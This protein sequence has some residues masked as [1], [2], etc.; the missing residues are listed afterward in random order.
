MASKIQ[1]AN[2]IYQ[3]QEMQ[4]IYKTGNSEIYKIF[5]MLP[6]TRLYK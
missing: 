6:P 4:T 2:E 5:N 1:E 3:I